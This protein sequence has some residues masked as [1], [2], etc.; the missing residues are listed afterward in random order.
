MLVMFRNFS[1]S[2][3]K[4]KK[5]INLETAVEDGKLTQKIASIYRLQLPFLG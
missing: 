2:P 4:K 5:D 3:D 1:K